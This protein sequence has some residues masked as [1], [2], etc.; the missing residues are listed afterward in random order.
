MCSNCGKLQDMPLSNRTYVCDCGLELDRDHNSAINI[1]NKS[2]GM[3]RAFVET[4]VTTSM[5]QEAISST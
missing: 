5:K 4:A 1:L 2:L 3:V